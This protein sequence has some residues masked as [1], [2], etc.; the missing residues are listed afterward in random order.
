MRSNE[1]GRS[2]DKYQRFRIA[3][4]GFHI[5]HKTP[6]PEGTYLDRLN[7]TR[8]SD[9]F[10]LKF[11]FFI[12][13]LNFGGGCH[14]GCFRDVGH[15]LLQTFHVKNQSMCL[16]TDPGHT[17]AQVGRFFQLLSLQLILLH[18]ATRCDTDIDKRF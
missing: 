11:E 8:L 13:T 12:I 2:G 17:I 9:D 1:A 4:C 6:R 16:H 18:F 5:A 10:E 14:G 15:T 3:D 7:K